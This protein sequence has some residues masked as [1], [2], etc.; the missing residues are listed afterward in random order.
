MDVEARTAV[1]VA[2]LEDAPAQ[3]LSMSAA[4]SYLRQLAAGRGRN[5]ASV[6]GG[7]L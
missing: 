6:G 2:L 4:E 3:S 7:D 1:D 5:P